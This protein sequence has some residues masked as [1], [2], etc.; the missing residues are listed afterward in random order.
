MPSAKAQAA[1]RSGRGPTRSCTGRRRAGALWNC[2]GPAA[3][4]DGAPALDPAADDPVGGGST[5]VPRP[6]R[7]RGS[8]WRAAAPPRDWRTRRRA[9]AARGGAGVGVGDHDRAAPVVDP[10]ARDPVV[11]AAA[12][13]APARH[14]VEQLL[15]D[16]PVGHRAA[17]PAGLFLGV[18]VDGPRRLG[19]RA[20]TC[21]L[22][23][24]CLGS[25]AS[26]L[27]PGAQRSAATLTPAPAAPRKR[28]C[29]V[30]KATWRSG[31][32]DAG[33]AQ[34]PDS[35]RRAR[36][37]RRP[38]PRSGDVLGVL[39]RVQPGRHLAVAAGA[40]LLDRVEHE[41]PCSGAACRGSGRPRRS[42]WRP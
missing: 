34:P 15:A 33:A 41:L 27:V 19:P 22:V 25:P 26:R 6:A 23:I 39:A 18:V 11:V 17:A 28:P 13:E 21:R 7:C 3:D 1:M 10:A 20:L 30:R 31:S 12:V 16:T 14:A 29:N 42:R 37:R 35:G 32:R 2:A 4:L 9:R 40:A 5:S 8:S 24:L 38:W 36:S